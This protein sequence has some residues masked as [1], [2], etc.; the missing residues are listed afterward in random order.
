MVVLSA[1]IEQSV[2][3]RH[4]NLTIDL[5]IDAGRQDARKIR[6]RHGL[7]SVVRADHPASKNCGPSDWAR[8]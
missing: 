5:P 6:N 2:A 8:L 7:Q 4:S 1:A 3:G